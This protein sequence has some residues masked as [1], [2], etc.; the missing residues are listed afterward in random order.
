[1][2]DLK[3]EWFKCSEGVLKNHV[4]IEIRQ[5]YC[6]IITKDQKIV[7]VSKN[8]KDWQFPGGHPDE[9]ESWQSTLKREVWEETGINIDE[10]INNIVKL[11][12]YLVKFP[13]EQFL[14]ERYL[15]VLDEKL[16]DL[17][18]KP[19]ENEE[20]DTPIIRY[21]EAVNIDQIGKY[22]PWALEV[23]GWN[24]ALSYYQDNFS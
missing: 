17:P 2:S 12:Y 8:N 20:D 11:G 1:M 24:S 7:I 23:E 14:Q 5:R 13:T 21:V 4:N 22:V 10:Q 16:G 3:T 18:L 9:N 6:F 19:H 15:L